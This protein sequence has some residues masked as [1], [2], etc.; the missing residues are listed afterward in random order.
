MLTA[1]LHYIVIVRAERGGDSTW[2]EV[3]DGDGNSV[4]LF[5]PFAAA[6]MMQKA[7]EAASASHATQ[8]PSA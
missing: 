2:L 1:N 4:A 5:M 7:F 3:A 6:L 8:E